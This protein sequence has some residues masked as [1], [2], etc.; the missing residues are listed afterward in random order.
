MSLRA[1]EGTSRP[2][3]ALPAISRWRARTVPDSVCTRLS[4]SARVARSSFV[5]R[6]FSN[7]RT[8]SARGRTSQPERV[9][10][11]LQVAAVGVV[12]AG[13]VPVA[14][15]DAAQFVVAD[16]PYAVIV[17][18]RVQRLDFGAQFV[19]VAC[20]HTDVH[21]AG[22]VVAVDV[23]AGDELTLQFHAFERNV[24]HETRIAL[25]HEFLEFFLAAGVTE[26]RLAAAASG[27]A[28]PQVFR[29]EQCDAEAAFHEMQRGG[30]AGDSASDD[31]DVGA[32]LARKRGVRRWRRSRR[33]VEILFAGATHGLS[34]AYSG[35]R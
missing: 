33:V 11:R 21:V 16:K 10:V 2:N 9:L 25:A 12:D 24:P 1:S 22:H 5:T 34:A 19:V 20:L 17:V 15:Y 23:V 14:I 28:E 29:F 35:P 6:E 8:P 18:L 13:G 30:Q 26:D 32:R 7:M 31:A 4:A 27:S 3:K